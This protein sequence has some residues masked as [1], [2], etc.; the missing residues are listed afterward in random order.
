LL[1]ALGATVLLAEFPEL[2]GAEQNLIDRT[3]DEGAARKFIDLMG[4]Y[5]QAAENAGSGFHMNPHQAILKMD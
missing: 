3:K 1:V 4:A 5:S 2:C